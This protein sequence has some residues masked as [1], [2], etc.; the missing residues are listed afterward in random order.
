MLVSEG[1]DTAGS[2]RMIDTAQDDDIGFV[3]CIGR[4]RTKPTYRLG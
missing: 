1:M 3:L 4:G 2:K